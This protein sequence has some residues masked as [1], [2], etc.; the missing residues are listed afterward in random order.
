M[1]ANRV[2]DK[3]NVKHLLRVQEQKKKKCAHT[4]EGQM[5]SQARWF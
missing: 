5:A 2:E 4:K 3:E 1:C